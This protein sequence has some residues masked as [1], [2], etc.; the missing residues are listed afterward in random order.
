M[1]KSNGNRHTT[2]LASELIWNPVLGIALSVFLSACTHG[3][4]LFS[5]PCLTQ[6]KVPTFVLLLPWPQSSHLT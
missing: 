5:A 1:N 4:V 6:L 2:V 3:V